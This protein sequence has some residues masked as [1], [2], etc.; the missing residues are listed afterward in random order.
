MP[1][2][3]REILL[4][5]FKFLTLIISL[6]I[7]FLLNRIEGYNFKQQH[8]LKLRIKDSKVAL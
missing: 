1:R 7:R 5:T 2:F 8:P 6:V 4:F 3:W